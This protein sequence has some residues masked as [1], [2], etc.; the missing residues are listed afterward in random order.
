[1]QGKQE[2]ATVWFVVSILLIIAAFGS[3]VIVGGASNKQPT[4]QLV[5]TQG[6]AFDVNYLNEVYAT[7][8][9]Q[10]LGNLP[11]TDTLT[12]SMAKGMVDALKDQ[13]SAFLDPVESEGYFDSMASAF[14]GIGVQLGYDG[15]YTTVD[16][17]LDGFPGQKA[18]LQSGD[19][20]LEVNG[21]D[22]S[23]Q[24]PETVATKIRG[25][26]GTDVNLKL[27]RAAEQRIFD[28]SITRGRI[29]LDN[30]SYKMLDNGIAIIDI[31]RF[32]EG[33]D[34]NQ[35]GVEVFKIDW[36]AIVTKVVA[37][38]PKGIIVDLRN[39]PGGY[40]QAVKYVAEEFLSSNQIVLQEQSKGG[41]L[42]KFIDERVGRLEQIPMVV[43]VNE[44]S[45]SASEIFAGAIQD[46]NRGKVVGGERTVGKG[47]E[48]R[49]LT[50]KD[51]SILMLV[52]RR[53]LTAG[54]RQLSKDSP[55][56]P[57]QIVKLDDKNTQNG[58]DPQLQKALELLGV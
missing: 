12:R 43:L 15:N 18:G 19:Q 11:D 34:G 28:V 41:D 24:R 36:D 54:G 1:M 52:F 48:Q 10:Y 53:W 51:N 26:A 31:T 8:E 16:T 37:E 50:M 56:I 39:N 33:D 7:I 47:V 35:S 27:Y 42:E 4:Q 25:E 23:G 45:A 6:S 2:K 5:A 38:N 22:V 58:Q 44:G 13:Y 49:L 57:D 17:P 55:I 46:N 14:E 40:V 9:D 29:D 20:I 3:G 21:E 30:I 32:T